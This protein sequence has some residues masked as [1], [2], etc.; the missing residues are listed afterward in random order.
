MVDADFM[1]GFRTREAMKNASR[2]SVRYNDERGK[3]NMGHDVGK[4]VKN[5][6]Y[7][8]WPVWYVLCDEGLN[9]EAYKSDTISARS[10][11][12]ICW[13]CFQSCVSI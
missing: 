9:A 3:G 6:R 7:A 2:N 1:V 11:L 12:L 5:V 10:G 8:L 13:P 4:F